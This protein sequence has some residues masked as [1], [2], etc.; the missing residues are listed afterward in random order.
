MYVAG[1]LKRKLIEK[2]PD[3]TSI[4]ILG[5]T[6]NRCSWI[7]QKEYKPDLLMLPSNE[8]LKDCKNIVTQFNLFH[9]EEIILEK[10]P[11]EKFHMTLDERFVGEVRQF[12]L[13][14]MGTLLFHQRLKVL[15]EKHIGQKRGR[16]RTYK[17]I[18]QLSC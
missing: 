11:M 14:W 4:Y 12:V 8:L 9:G 15:N 1:R 13:S 6:K 5:E 2:F 10:N 7:K 17:Q 18:S 3:D 16:K